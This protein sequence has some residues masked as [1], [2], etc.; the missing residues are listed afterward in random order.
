MTLKLHGRIEKEYKSYFIIVHTV[1]RNKLVYFY[2][3]ATYL[4]NSVENMN[5]GTNENNLMHCTNFVILL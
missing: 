5:Y 4:P 2:M 3:Y 1:I